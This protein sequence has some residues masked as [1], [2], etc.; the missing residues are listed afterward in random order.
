MGGFS[1]VKNFLYSSLRVSVRP[2]VPAKVAALSA[3]LG[4]LALGSAAGLRADFFWLGRRVVGLGPVGGAGVVFGGRGKLPAIT[5]SLAS[6]LVVAPAA[7]SH[8]PTAALR[9]RVKFW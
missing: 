3:Q 6:K 4:M 1:V 8:R 2:T 7:I 9:R 5:G